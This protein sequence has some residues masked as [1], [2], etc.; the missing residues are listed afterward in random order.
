[1]TEETMDTIERRIQAAEDLATIKTQVSEMHR[2]L[3]GTNGLVIQVQDMQ[4]ALAK[5]TGMVM[6]ASAVVSL[7]V[8]V[9]GWKVKSWL[10]HT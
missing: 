6:G 9:I 2:L 10:G 3:V 5:Q 1:M 4:L 8:S 7:V